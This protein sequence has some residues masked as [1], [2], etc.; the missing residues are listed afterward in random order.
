M[1][2]VKS[3]DQSYTWDDGRGAM[4]FE[5]G[6]SYSVSE[7]LAYSKRDTSPEDQ[8]AIHNVKKIFDGVLVE[9][10]HKLTNPVEELREKSRI[11]FE[12]WKQTG[13]LTPQQKRKF[14]TGHHAQR[15]K[16]ENR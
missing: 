14:Y 1:P 4:V 11:S 16:N 9:K 6:V 7:L 12:Y 8:R 13:F 5:D 15:R 2:F 10:G 3:L